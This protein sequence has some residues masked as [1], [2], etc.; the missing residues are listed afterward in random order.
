MKTP[1]GAVTNAQGAVMA[2]SPAS[3]PLQSMLTSG[4]P[5]RSFMYRYAPNAP[6]RRGEHRVHGDDRDAGVHRRTSVE[7]GIE[8][9]PAEREDERPEHAIGMLCPG[10]GSRP[11]VGAVL[12]DARP[13]HLGAD[14]RGDAARQVDDRAAGEVDVAVAEAEVRARAATASRRPRPSCA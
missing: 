3:M 9:E 1:I 8:A 14:E 5:K 10:I 7:P 13:E 4:L 11:A 2:T 12:A 6:L